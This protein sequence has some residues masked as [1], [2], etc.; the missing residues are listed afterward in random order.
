M[1]LVSI[2]GGAAADLTDCVSVVNLKH[3]ELKVLELSQGDAN[4]FSREILR[5]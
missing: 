2:C 3:G 1:I 4:G 5:P